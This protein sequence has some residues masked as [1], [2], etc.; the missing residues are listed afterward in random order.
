MGVLH[1]DIRLTGFAVWYTD[2]VSTF[3]FKRYLYLRIWEKCAA[4]YCKYYSQNCEF[5]ISVA[6]LH[7]PSAFQ[8]KAISS[9]L[10]LKLMCSNSTLM[11]ITNPSDS[12]P[13]RPHRDWFETG[14]F[15]G[16]VCWWKNVWQMPVF[17]VRWLPTVTSAL[18]ASIA[19]WAQGS[20]AERNCGSLTQ[21]SEKHQ[22]LR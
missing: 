4:F 5:L 17:W 21:A 3:V 22:G 13:K 18:S 14:T 19:E 7:K 1:D 9:C 6:K 12:S 16:I 15:Y 2:L 8:V 11:P 10:T 20:A